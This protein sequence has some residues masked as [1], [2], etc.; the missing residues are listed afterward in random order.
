MNI[1]GKNI[2]I[3]GSG[4]DLTGRRLASFVDGWPGVVVRCNKVYGDPRDIGRRTDLYFTRW[5][6]WVGNITPLQDG[7]EYVVINDARGITPQEL[8]IIGQE[9]GVDHVSCGAVAV[10]WCLHR[11]ARSV[12]VMGY[13]YSP[14]SRGF[15]PKAYAAKY[16]EKRGLPVTRYNAD[17][18]THYDWAREAAW[19]IRC[20]RVRLL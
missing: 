16:E 15:F 17:K 4:V 12:S 6:S 19:L 7:A 2:L 18:N 13:G 11:G 10:A 8:Q 5:Q 1:Q 9:I 14:H 3:V 20:P